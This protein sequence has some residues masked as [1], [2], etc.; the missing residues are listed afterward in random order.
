MTDKINQ[1][2]YELRNAILEETGID[3]GITGLNVT[4]EL[5]NKLIYLSYNKYMTSC[6]PSDIYHTTI[7]GIKL[8]PK[9][10]EK[11]KM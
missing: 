4:Y 8:I 2:I 10:L 5:Y 3:N 11:E 1:A 7:Q 9:E 6:S